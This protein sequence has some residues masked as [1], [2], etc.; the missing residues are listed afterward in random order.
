MKNGS[1]I[2][3]PQLTEQQQLTELER[4]KLENFALKHT[5]LQQQV[6]AN[7]IARAGFIQQIEAAHP[8]YRWNDQSGLV[9][10][11]PTAIPTGGT[12]AD[13]TTKREVR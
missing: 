13:P 12:A 10:E 2:E 11:G 5:A 8:G 7:L 4:V 3:Q 1:G 6:Q 9:K